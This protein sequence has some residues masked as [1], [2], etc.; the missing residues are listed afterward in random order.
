MKITAINKATGEVIELP[1]NNPVEIVLAWRIAQEYEKAAQALKDQLKRLVPNIVG[2]RGLSEPIGAFQFRSSYIQRTTYDKSIMRQEL[3]ADTFDLLLVPDK[4]AID[5]YLKEN[6]DTIG[7]IG[8]T[9]RKTMITVGNP[10]SVIK[11]E[12]IS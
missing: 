8:T 6:I 11:L 2:D 4:P 3:N 12:R 5:K 10:Y 1:A 7:A 9:L